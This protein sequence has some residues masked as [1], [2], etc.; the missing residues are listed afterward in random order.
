M[1]KDTMVWTESC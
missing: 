1:G